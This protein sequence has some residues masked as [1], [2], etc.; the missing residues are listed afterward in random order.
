MNSAINYAVINTRLRH[1]DR[2]TSNELQD[3]LSGYGFKRF[4]RGGR[5]YIS[6][7]PNVQKEILKNYVELLVKNVPADLDK[8]PLEYAVLKT[9]QKFERLGL[10]KEKALDQMTDNLFKYTYEGKVNAFTQEDEARNKMLQ[11]EKELSKYG[12]N[13]QQFVF[14]EVSDFITYNVTSKDVDLSELRS[15]KKEESLNKVEE[16]RVIVKEDY[17][18]DYAAILDNRVMNNTDKMM[19]PQS[20]IKI[21]KHLQAT[22]S[23]GAK[24]DKQADSVLLMENKDNPDYKFMLV[25][26]GMGGTKLGDVASKYI[27]DN[28]R[29]WYKNLG[30][31][32][33]RDPKFA[34][35]IE[36][37]VKKLST[38]LYKKYNEGQVKMKAGSTMIGAFID[39]NGVLVASVGDSRA[40]VSKDGNLFEVGENAGKN[41]NKGTAHATYSDMRYMMDFEEMGVKKEDMRFF[42]DSH[43]IMHCMGEEDAIK[44]TIWRLDREEFDRVYIGSDGAFNIPFNELCA[45][46][47]NTPARD[48]SRVGVEE[49]V[50]GFFDKDRKYVKVP[51]YIEKNPELKNEFK[52]Q[53]YGTDNA[54]IA[55]YDRDDMEK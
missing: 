26:D 3:E 31:Y 36:E 29:E 46:N 33:T 24:R 9:Y 54:T 15:E 53:E 25:A 32:D 21:G 27:V 52:N 5:K 42:K 28:M 49:A 10:N 30:K 47:R 50:Y 16:S 7:V 48:L 45:I 55:V 8:K 51:E 6:E 37:Q 4:S 11:A 1:L 44:P 12:F 2:H 40:F 22:Q 14:S 41:I 34:K 23:I 39:N 19:Y 38:E 18:S 20:T 35:Q 17:L 43:V 13:S